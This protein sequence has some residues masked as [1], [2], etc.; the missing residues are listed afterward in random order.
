MSDRIN[1]LVTGSM[2]AEQNQITERLDAGVEYPGVLF[3][4]YDQA[5]I[6]MGCSQR[7]D[8]Q[9]SARSMAAGLPIMRRNSGGGAVLAGPWM[10]SI[11]VFIPTEHLIA[12]QNIIQIFGWLEQ[13]WIAA[14]EKCNVPCKGVDKALIDHSKEVSESQNLKWACYASLS[15]GEVVSEDGRKLVG[16]AQI[17]KKKGVVLVS[18]LHLYPCDW[19]QLSSIVVDNPEQGVQLE[20]LNSDAQSLSGRA[21]DVLLPEIIQAFHEQLPDDFR[22]LS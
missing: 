5:A 12:Q 17:R 4:Q 15:H 21:E 3:W 11:S 19:Q 1:Y 6:I 10:L 14:L 20:A 8:E 13:I 22:V 9:Q 7:P 18:G 16:L 2:P